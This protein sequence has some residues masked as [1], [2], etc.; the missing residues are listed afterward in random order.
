M[1]QFSLA[2]FALYLI[3]VG[4]KGNS[5]PLVALVKQEGGYVPWLVAV[6][7]LA[8]LYS[9]ETTRPFV[10]PF[11]GLIVLVLILRNWPTIQ[12]EGGAI[13]HQLT[14]IGASPAPATGA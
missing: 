6:G 4:V 13:Y 2:I 10:K 9:A 12:Q 1:T 11:A 14:S 7:V 3:L 5:A 8:A